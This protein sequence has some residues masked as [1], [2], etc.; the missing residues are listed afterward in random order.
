MPAYNA[1]NTVTQTFNEIPRDLVDHII[2]V[3][4]GSQDNTAELA[5]S[6]GY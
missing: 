3:D 1:A 5:R 2:L 6:L 4:D